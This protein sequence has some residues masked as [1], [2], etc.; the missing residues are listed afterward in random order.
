[1]V[2]QERI[3]RKEIPDLGK[4]FLEKDYVEARDIEVMADNVAFH[5]YED[6]VA[7]PV[8]ERNERTN[9]V[10]EGLSINSIM[11]LVYYNHG[12]VYLREIRQQ[13]KIEGKSIK[14][15][16]SDTEDGEEHTYFYNIDI[17]EIMRF[18]DM[19]REVVL[20]RLKSKIEIENVDFDLVRQQYKKPMFKRKKDV[21]KTRKLEELHG[22]KL[23]K[24][25]RSKFI[26][27]YAAERQVAFGQL[28]N[29]LKDE[30][31]DY[32]ANPSMIVNKE[33]TNMLI[34][35]RRMTTLEDFLKEEY[36]GAPIHRFKKALE[37]LLDNMRGAEYLSKNGLILMD[38]C[39]EN[40]GIDKEAGKGFLFDYDG[41]FRKGE[42]IR[43]RLRHE[44]HQPPWINLSEYEELTEAE[45]VFQFGRSIMEIF[46]YL[47]LSKY[48][49]R[50]SKIGNLAEAMTD[51]NKNEVLTID[52][53][54]EYLEAV[55]KEL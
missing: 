8:E 17:N 40:C 10:I 13:G 31:C 28:A 38:I 48:H 12:G 50:F 1:M 45:M 41:M 6:L 52:E 42:K 46:Q 23:F 32:V 39:V 36:E 30:P 4:A 51:Y 9:V 43:G 35:K 20:E 29:A 33:G 53:A 14:M 21:N 2:K 37:I 49:E 7:V 19:I 26:L 18:L 27:G 15:S 44:H 11:D 34:E 5:I 55:I 24:E 3:T 54:I 22:G 16:Y 47:H 25:Y